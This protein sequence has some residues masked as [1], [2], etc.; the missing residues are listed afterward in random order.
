[1]RRRHYVAFA[2]LVGVG[3]AG[4]LLLI[5]RGPEQ[6]LI[7]YRDKDFDEALERYE[8]RLESGDLS[9]AVVM[10][11][12]QL[13]LQYGN[14]DAAV[15]LM[16]RY[17]R[18]H[19]DDVTAR[20]ELGRYYQFAQRGPEY[21]AELET[22]SRLAPSEQTLRRLSEIYNF[23][24]RF[25]E[26]IATLERLVQL[27]PGSPQDLVDMA[28]MMAARGRLTEA[29]AALRRLHDTHPEAAT[30]ETMQ[31][32]LSTLL[33]SGQPDAAVAEGRRWLQQHR[34]PAAAARLASTIGFKGN[35]RQ[36][37]EL[38]GPF[39]S[40][41]ARSP[42]LLAELTQ[43]ELAN[44]LQDR[45]L[46]RLAQLDA[47]NRLPPTALEPYLD[48]LLTAG[49]TGEA[50]DVAR[51]RDVAALPPW[52]LASL[53]DAALASG[54]LETIERITA[55]AG[56]GFFEQAPVLGARL[57]VARQDR[58]GAE[59]WIQA[60][61]ARQRT[62]DETIGLG[63][64]YLAVGEPGAAIDVLRPLT[65]D[66]SAPEAV[67][68]DLANLYLDADRAAEG[69]PVV[70]AARARRRSPAIDGRW[71]LLAASAGDIEPV[72]QWLQRTPNAQVSDDVLEDLYY[73][74]SDAKEAGLAADAASRLF[75]RRGTRMWR[76]QLATS[77]SAAG[78]PADALPHF[79]A[80]LPGDPAIESGYVE[81]LRAAQAMGVPVRDEL[82]RYWAAR[83]GRSGLS[84][85]EQEEVVYALLDLQDL[86]AAVPALARLARR[87]GG[88]WLFAYADA[89]ARAGRTSDLV[90]LLTSEL[91]GDA[92]TSAANEQRLQLLR[93]HG[94]ASVALPYL[95]R[96]AEARGGEWIEAYEA[97]LVATGRGEER[98]RFWREYGGRASTAAADRR[99]IAFRSLEAGEKAIAESIWRDLAASAPPDSPDVSQLLYLWGP[100][101]RA[102]EIDWIASR[103]EAASGP[104]REGW[105]RV[106]IDAGAPQRALDVGRG[107]F[108]P[109]YL[110]AL[111]AA[112]DA[113]ALNDAVVARVAATSSAD[114]LR[115]LGNA[116]LQLGQRPAMRAAFGKLLTIAPDDP[117]AL[118]RLGAIDFAESRFAEGR[119]RL[120]RYAAGGGADPESLFYLG[121][122]LARDREMAAARGYFER[123]LAGIDR[124]AQ[125]GPE[126]QA[127]RALALHRVGRLDEAFA[128]FEAL[129]AAQPRNTQLRA[130]YA[131]ALMQSARF[132]EARR[133]LAIP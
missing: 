22:L 94:S 56:D 35:K 101:P 93:E 46:S 67:V 118:R 5:T 128:A 60:A 71:A 40:E 3:L 109:A 68:V 72:R 90:D 15:T 79:R 99:G 65:Q 110:D 107:S 83:L 43:L 48:L 18:E 26:Q 116:A 131:A 52:L 97:A 115:R 130:D 122:L 44:G 58:A 102:T 89:A 92:T 24:S 108:S 104:Q 23:Q 106:L 42:E 70:A 76:L 7:S 55:R 36:A 34:D 100:R 20:T 114:E 59:R 32:L 49:R 29:A 77:L 4:S 21:L 95:R 121:E 91:D 85:E 129:I 53:V 125:P 2:L 61:L 19:P 33:D 10:P 28:T 120:E 14:V 47:A 8:A 74:A 51:R 80:L 133:V 78:R 63:Q 25:D 98:V 75:T 103:A 9:P 69:L 11:L 119:A 86:D 13:Y 127:I 54:Q 37:L 64:V 1:M 96:F 126:L 50:L 132:E 84:E 87:E 73:V 12:S 124:L 31:F 38:L 105:M 17:V 113:R 117:E 66:P 112:S 6:A 39:T 57:A 45:A 16:E 27:Y 82:R 41:A 30:P 123:A 62:A 88:Q 81:A 111:V